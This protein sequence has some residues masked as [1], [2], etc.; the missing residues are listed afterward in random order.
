M[1][2][3]AAPKFAIKLNLIEDENDSPEKESRGDVKIQ[4]TI[5]RA[6]SEIVN[7]RQ[8][9]RSVQPYPSISD[10]YNELQSPSKADITI[11]S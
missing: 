6:Y 4:N 3:S 11:T 8:M 7:D 10:M 2:E 1:N 9:E 5:D